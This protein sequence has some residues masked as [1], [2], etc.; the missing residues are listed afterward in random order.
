ML[1]H[2]ATAEGECA[3]KNAMGQETT[4]SYKAIPSCI[5]TSP[6]VASVGLSE[7]EAKDKF[8]IQVGRFPF[9][10]CGKALVLNET[11]GMVKI[12]A[13]KKH[14]EV[15]GVHIIGPHA[16]DM[17]A[18]AVLGMSMKMTVEQL[19]HAVHPHPTLSDA[20]KESALSLCGG[21]IHM[22]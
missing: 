8:D 5:Y 12:I 4:M 2:V 21:A 3:A 7:E 6:E 22:P 16:T 18:E 9:H 13:E 17:I 15:L 14:G 11:Y 1:A 20:I 19:A 10:G